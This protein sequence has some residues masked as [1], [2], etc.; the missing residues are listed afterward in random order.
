MISDLISVLY[1][2]EHQ[3]SVASFLDN[4]P[5]VPIEEV[6]LT[7][8][9][10]ANSMAEY[11]LSTQSAYFYI[12]DP[13][14]VYASDML[15]QLLTNLQQHPEAGTAATTHRF[16][17]DT[18]HLIAPPYR[19]FAPKLFGKILQGVEILD[20]E[21]NSHVNIL[22]SAGCCLFDINLIRKKS[23]EDILHLVRF[24]KDKN[25]LNSLIKE[26]Q[27]H[28]S[29]TILSA[30]IGKK[31]SPEILHQKYETWH[32]T[33]PFP[34]LKTGSVKKEITFFY[35]DGGE[36]R[37][38]LPIAEEANKR[39]FKIHFTKDTNANAEI[40]VYCQHVCFPENSRFSVI[41]LHDMLQD[42]NHWPNLWEVEP[43]D[44]FNIGIRLGR[45]MEK[46]RRF[47]LR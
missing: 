7:K 46:M 13:D 22:G 2:A 6:C 41:L 31:V 35:T 14:F 37:N 19:K 33:K 25:I 11:I 39:G 43:W 8:D 30:R 5:S 24:S 27:I 23:A 34:P 15:L 44:G 36:Y 38:V 26:C 17:D 40:G 42:Y 28:F 47:I 45:T 4:N 9:D 20:M 10:D 3:Q 12:Y 18:F 29:E 21:E 1:N 16:A 32:F